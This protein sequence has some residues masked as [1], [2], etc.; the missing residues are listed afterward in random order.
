LAQT[1]ASKDAKTRYRE[2]NRERIRE[3]QRLHAERKRREAGQAIRGSEEWKAKVRILIEPS[4]VGQDHPNW[5]GDAAGYGALHDWV[6]RWRPKTGI[7]SDCKASGRRT[8]WHN[9]SGHYHRN[10]DDWVEVCPSCH[11]RRDPMSESGRARIAA[12][13]R[14]RIVSADTRA[15]LSA[16]SKKGWVKRRKR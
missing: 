4:P 12:A 13:N 1:Q 10:L 8:H 6:K 3:T 2:R 11:K 7:C 15:K 9:L 14:K 5:K 16:S